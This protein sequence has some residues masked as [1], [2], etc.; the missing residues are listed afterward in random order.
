MSKERTLYFKTFA[1]HPLLPNFCVPDERD[2]LTGLNFNP[3]NTQCIPAVK[4][5][6]FLELEQ[7]WAFF[8]GL[9]FYK[10]VSYVR[11]RTGRKLYPKYFS[12]FVYDQ[13]G[14]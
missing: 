8:K 4:I 1:K 9:T 5:I 13:L 14:L 6:A 7:N 11:N 10:S 12:R 3:Q 2:L